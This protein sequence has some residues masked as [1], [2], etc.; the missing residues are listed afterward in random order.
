MEN[1]YIKFLEKLESLSEELNF[2]F[3]SEKVAQ[4][5]SEI[6]ADFNIDKERVNDFLL[7]F[8]ISDFKIEELIKNISPDIKSQE[9]LNEFI[10]DFL[11]K[12]FLP[13]DNFIDFKVAD[14][15]KK[16]NG[17]LDKYKQ[18]VSDFEES[19]VNS[20]LNNLNNLLEDLEKDFDEE[21][22]ERI[23]TY[24]LEKDLVTILK[25]SD[26]SAPRSLNGSMLYL[27]TNKIDSLDKFIRALLANQE[28]LTKNLLIIN[29][30]KE[31]PTIANWIKSFIKENGSNNF[32]N[33]VLAKFLTSSVNCLN[34][35]EVERRLVRKV[36][37]LY[38]NLSFFPD[39]MAN[40]PFNEWEIVPLDRDNII[41]DSLSMKKSKN[42]DEVGE[43]NNVDVLKNNSE[44]ISKNDLEKED[45][46]KKEN[47][48]SEKEQKIKEMELM[49][50]KYPEKSLERKAIESEINKLKK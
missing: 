31:D 40:I 45:L 35:D 12:L 16:Y 19:I 4:A 8:F 48:F 1:K 5:I 28:V 43:I 6:S 2:Y 23:S 15:I 36:L 11:G 38:R 50:E 17:S 33:I 7:D 42:I 37:R 25:N 41:S 3:S 32:S 26:P 22:E 9:R 21:K 49:L 47:F 27:L 30:K 14:Q 34:L 44:N 10:C 46:D 39:S 29:N 18:Y 24:L 20:N 13:V